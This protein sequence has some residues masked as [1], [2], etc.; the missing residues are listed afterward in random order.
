MLIIKTKMSFIKKHKKTKTG[1]KVYKKKYFRTLFNNDIPIGMITSVS[2]T[3]G[4][5][6][7]IKKP[8]FDEN[9]FGWNQELQ[10]VFKEYPPIPM[11]WK[12]IPTKIFKGDEHKTLTSI[13]R[14]IANETESEKDTLGK[15][16][17]N[18]YNHNFT[19]QVEKDELFGMISKIHK[20]ISDRMFYKM[21]NSDILISL[22]W[23]DVQGFYNK[24]IENLRH[25][26]FDILNRAIELDYENYLK[27]GKYYDKRK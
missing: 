12:N 1:K 5:G 21:K 18:V 9:S 25:P 2:I 27:Y 11:G 4:T 23:D 3:R 22:D 13:T 14:R 7:N 19:V 16:I 6:N 26:M 10:D 17:S 24:V 15:I 8:V 20:S